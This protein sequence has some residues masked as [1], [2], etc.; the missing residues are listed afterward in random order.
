M[1]ILELSL[2]YT[3]LAYHNSKDINFLM[4]VLTIIQVNNI[5]IYTVNTRG[6]N[7]S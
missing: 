6:N 2:A 4:N 5:Q 1:F 3:K 7:S